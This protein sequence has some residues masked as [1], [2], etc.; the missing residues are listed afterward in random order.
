MLCVTVHPGEAVGMHPPVSSDC[1]NRLPSRIDWLAARPH[2][3]PGST[4]DLTITMCSR[5]GREFGY[6]GLRTSGNV[7]QY[8]LLGLSEASR[9]SL[10]LA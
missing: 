8:R 3:A 4:D 6:P 9:K 10:H 5:A 7:E 1:G 2:F